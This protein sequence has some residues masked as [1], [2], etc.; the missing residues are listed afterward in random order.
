MLHHGTLS[1]DSIPLSPRA[2]ARGLAPPEEELHAP[3][4]DPLRPQA[5]PV[6]K[7][8]ADAGAEVKVPALDGAMLDAETVRQRAYSV[9]TVTAFPRRSS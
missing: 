7:R 2:R 5:S 8:Y 6:R 9:A 3:R 4:P 1:H